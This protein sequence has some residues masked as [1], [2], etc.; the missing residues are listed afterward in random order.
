MVSR[1]NLSKSFNYTPISFTKKLK[2]P[3]YTEITSLLSAGSAQF[4]RHVQSLLLETENNAKDR[5]RQGKTPKLSV[6]GA[7]RFFVS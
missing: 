4:W 2:K 5:P 1:F 7:G 3:P 6:Y